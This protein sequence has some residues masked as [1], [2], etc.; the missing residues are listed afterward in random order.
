MHPNCVQGRAM[1]PVGSVYFNKLVRLIFAGGT[2][3]I[4]IIAVAGIMPSLDAAAQDTSFGQRL[5]QDKADCQYCHGMDGDGRGSPQSRGRAANLRTTRLNRDQLIE[6]IACG[7]PGTEMPH[8]DKY[9]YDETKCC[10]RSAAELGSDIPH[11]PH[12]TSLTAREIEA[13][14]DYILAT[15]AGK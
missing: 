13:V 6:V 4:S 2:P 1:S 12:S 10:G 9:A 7:R 15:F 3:T 11:D 5:F 8:F 14:V